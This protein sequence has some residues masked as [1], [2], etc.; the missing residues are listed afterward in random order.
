[1]DGCT[2]FLVQLKM[3]SAAFENTV[4][5][6]ECWSSELYDCSSNPYTVSNFSEAVYLACSGWRISM[7]KITYLPTFREA[8]A[9][10][11]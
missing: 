5:Y 1:M 8:K 11:L 10:D 9:V 4:V 2:C 6:L 7:A 3:Y